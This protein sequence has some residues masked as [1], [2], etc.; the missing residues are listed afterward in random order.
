MEVPSLSDAV[1]AITADLYYLSSET[2]ELWVYLDHISGVLYTFLASKLCQHAQV[3]WDVQGPSA[4]GHILVKSFCKV[5]V[6]CFSSTKSSF[7]SPAGP[8]S[9]S[10]LDA[11][12]FQ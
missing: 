9:E 1:S 10:G 6:K 12:F 5:G 4:N 8:L 7:T 11:V 2:A 3:E